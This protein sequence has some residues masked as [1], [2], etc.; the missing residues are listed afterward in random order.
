MG[1][2]NRVM[3]FEPFD[4]RQHFL[5][6]PE[7]L[8]AVTR[9]AK[10]QGLKVVTTNGCFD[11][12]HRG[13]VHLLQEAAQQGDILIVGLNSDTSVRQNKGEQRP[14]VPENERAE[15]LLAIEEV[16]YVYLYNEPTCVPFVELAQPDV[17]VNDASYGEDCVESQAVRAG[18]GRLHL[19]EKIDCPS[20]SELIRRIVKTSNPERGQNADKQE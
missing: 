17:H 15:L 20:T 19:V 12:L 3:K 2:R 14:L 10:A 16:D 11:L 9:L 1:G 8:Q 13:H 6:T 7:Q 18:G 5:C 4:W